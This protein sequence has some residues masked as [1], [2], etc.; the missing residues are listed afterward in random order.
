MEKRRTKR[1][2]RRLSVAFGCTELDQAGI[3]N[4]ISANGLFIK[5]TKCYR[6]GCILKIQIQIPGNGMT[7]IK[8]KVVRS[9]RNPPYTSL[10]GNGVGVEISS[11]D[12]EYITH[13]SCL[14]EKPLE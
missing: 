9:F 5:T 7:S 8:G 6:P 13:F 4:D 12:A 3:T 10:A 11:S 1:I 14:Q 2:T